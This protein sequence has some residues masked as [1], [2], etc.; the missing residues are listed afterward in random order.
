MIKKTAVHEY[1][2]SR[3]NK[4][5]V[6]MKLADQDEAIA[7]L[8]A[9]EGDEIL[10]CS[11]N[12][13]MSRYPISLIPATAPKSKGVK[14]MNLVEDQVCSAC[15]YHN[16]TA[17]LLVVSDTGAMKRL[18]MSDIDLT[19]R[20]VKGN[21]ICKKVKSKPYQIAVIKL[22]DIQEQFTVKAQENYPL[23]MKDI[24]LMSREATFSQPLGTLQDFYIEQ[25]IQAIEQIEIPAQTEKTVGFEELNLEL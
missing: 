1:E 20:P 14:A 3:N 10:L 6:N 11:K 7:S 4:T 25:G 9:Y 2:V 19:G 8:L 15:I 18:K 23:N 22:F 17:Q 13:Y 24:S 16:D 12:G 5:M 21:M